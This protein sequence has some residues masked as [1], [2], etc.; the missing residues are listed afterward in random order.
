MTDKK[1]KI[2]YTVI[3]ILLST[4]FLAGMAIFFSGGISGRHAAKDW[5]A[6]IKDAILIDY[7]SSSDTVYALISREEINE[8]GDCLLVLLKN[9]HGSWKIAYEN[10]F[11][12]LKPWKIDG[13]DINDD[14]A[15]EILIAVKKTTM[16]DREEKNRMFIFNYTDGI[17]V[18]KWTGSQIAGVWRD[19]CTGQLFSAPGSELLFIEQTEDGCERIKVYNW[20]DFGFF[21][22]AESG[23]YSTI[24]SLVVTGEN[25]LQVTINEGYGER[26]IV[27]YPNNG[28]LGEEDER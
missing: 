13:A 14:G 5:K 11:T 27:L 25:S 9:P 23:K 4:A 15:D 24:K 1:S 16:F 2:L 22:T 19:F 18:K 10:D 20:F 8:Y 26:T 12:G 17:L 6:L 28:I 21:L 7:T 3:P